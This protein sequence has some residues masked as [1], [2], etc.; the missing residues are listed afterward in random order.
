M[1]VTDMDIKQLDYTDDCIAYIVDNL[2]ELND[3]MYKDLDSIHA[4]LDSFFECTPISVTKLLLLQGITIQFRNQ[5]FFTKIKNS[6][7]R[8][9][10]NNANKIITISSDIPLNS[11]ISTLHHEIGHA[12]DWYVS[13]MLMLKEQDRKRFSSKRGRDIS[14]LK[15][16]EGYIHN[17]DYHKSKS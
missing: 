6:R 3:T 17:L 16:E 7:A 4:I 5:D 12:V 1:V 9:M 14:D 13:S 15:D 2:F 10:Y 11:M 8:G